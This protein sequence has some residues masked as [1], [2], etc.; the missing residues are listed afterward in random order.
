MKIKIHILLLTLAVSVSGCSDFLDKSPEL[1]LTDTD[2]YTSAERMDGAVKGVYT[3]IKE[4]FIGAKAFACVENIGDDMINVS[5]NGYEALASYE[6]SVGMETQ[7]NYE[8][9][10][11]AYTA[12]NSANTVMAEIEAHKETAGNKYD[13]YI[14][15]LKFCRA[16]CYYYLNM[17]YAQPYL[18]DPQAK[19]VPLRLQAE[20][21]LENN[22]LARSTVTEVFN[23]ILEDT[24]DY[25]NLPASGGSYAGITRAS[26]GAALMLRMRAY[27]GMDNWDE[28]IK[29]GEAVQG[30]ALATGAASPFKSSSDCVESIFSFPMSSTNMGGGMQSSVPYFFYSGNSLV[31]DATSGIHSPLYPDYNLSQDERI[32]VLVGTANERTI[33]KKFTDG[34]TY[35]DWV[36][37]FRYAETLLNLAEC[38]AMKGLDEQA[39]DALSKVRHR[40]IPEADDPL[41]VEALHGDALKQAV[42]LER[43]AEFI[44][45]TIRAIDIHRRGEDFVKRKG[46][47]NEFTVTPTTNGYI[48]P[49]PTVER[50]NNH[51]ITD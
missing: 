19:S 14:S 8:S 25:A 16:L 41:E 49:I 26:Q 40:S 12:I 18:I 48:W 34:Q 21:G 37:I 2:I 36:P 1:N 39:V 50:A 31:V 23:Q 4:D 7:D 11:G 29:A 9:W 47:S 15:E 10:E 35:L 20:S 24:K 22:D 5:G 30:Y 17:L 44:G 43:R 51:L 46:T 28:A 6:M 33:L 13:Q 38:Y 32:S 45:E 27:M 42:Y 3:Q